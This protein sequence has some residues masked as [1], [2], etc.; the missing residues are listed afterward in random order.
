MD[1]DTIIRKLTSRKFWL[2]VCSFVSLLITAS[3]L[4][5][6]TAAKASAII[7]AGATVLA[8]VIAEGLTDVAY[9]TGAGEAAEVEGPAAAGRRDLLA[10]FVEVPI[11]EDEDEGEDEGPIIFV[12]DEDFIE[13]LNS[14]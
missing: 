4:G 11:D 13:A 9:A 8:Y 7:M 12:P 10:G 1:K 14:R 3:G 5:E 2:S 6:G